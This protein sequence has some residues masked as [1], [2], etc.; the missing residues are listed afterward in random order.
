MLV[1]SSV[2]YVNNLNE[3]TLGVVPS[4]ASALIARLFNLELFIGMVAQYQGEIMGTFILVMHPGQARPTEWLLTALANVLSIIYRRKRAERARIESESRFQNLAEMLPQPI[5]ECDLSGQITY[6][7]RMGLE[8]FGYPGGAELNPSI[9]DL[10]AAGAQQEVAQANMRRIMQGQAVA[11][12]EYLARRKDG[13]T[14]PV[15]MYSGPIIQNAQIKGMRGAVVDITERKA[16]EEALRVSEEKFRSIIEQ[17]S[18]GV[19]LVDEGGQVLELNQA[20]EVIYGMPKAEILGKSFWEMTSQFIY[21]GQQG[22]DVAQEAREDFKFIVTDNPDNLTYMKES[23]FIAP[24]GRLRVILRM[25]FPIVVSQGRRMAVM[26]RDITEQK[27][28]ERKLVRLNRSLRTASKCNLAL[29]RAMSEVELIQSFCDEISLAGEYPLVWVDRIDETGLAF[30]Q[31]APIV[32]ATLDA[33]GLDIRDLLPGTHFEANGRDL[34]ENQQA[35][36]LNQLSAPENPAD[37]G[38]LIQGVAQTGAQGLALLPLGLNGERYGLL[39]VATAKKDR[40]DADERA[41]LNEL[42]ADLSFGIH[43]LRVR[44][45]RTRNQLLLEQSNEELAAAYDATL[46]GWSRALELREQ[47]TAGHSSRVVEISVQL[48]RRLH[49]PEQEIVHVRRGALLHDIGKMGVPDAILLKKGPLDAEEWLIMRQHTLYAEKMLS[50]ID[51]LAPSLAIPL[52]HHENWDGQGY[53]H[54]LRGEEIPLTARIFAIVDVWDALTSTRSYRSGW[55]VEK[56][57]A[58]LAEKSGSQFDP[59]VVQAFF[60]YL[61][62]PLH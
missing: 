5:Y 41:L 53:P 23:E 26:V 16:V 40:F 48:S 7:N 44:T 36:W 51:H 54:G 27:Q 39:I 13:S 55:P 2:L 57:R 45:D 10:I 18:E 4:A 32:G 21:P 61:D 37:L 58:Y 29:V 33:S 59:R 22:E 42:A 34:V 31:D 56:V 6:A 47:E 3:A 52:C 20:F 19:M 17:S 43:T 1:K 11:P 15:L 25:A 8:I 35:V 9:F 28:A 24:D 62:E 38:A 46:V 30:R 60:D 12:S 14:F 50:G 49:I